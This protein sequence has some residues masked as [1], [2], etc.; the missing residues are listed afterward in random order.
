MPIPHY[1]VLHLNNYG[2]FYK[3]SIQTNYVYQI[4]KIQLS[5]ELK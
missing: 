2:K 4:I 1:A 3:T 5:K